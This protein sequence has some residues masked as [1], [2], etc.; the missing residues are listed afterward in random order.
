MTFS[1]LS[2]AEDPSFSNSSMSSSSSS[3]FIFMVILSFLKELFV[4]S[5]SKSRFRSFIVWV[6]TSFWAGSLAFFICFCKSSRVTIRFFFRI[7]VE[8]SVPRFSS[9]LFKPFM[10][11]FR[12]SL[13]CESSVPSI[14]F[15][16]C[17]RAASISCLWTSCDFSFFSFRA[18]GSTSCTA[19]M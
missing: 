9:F 8:S 5:F 17:S 6:R 12:T 15:C 3:P 14:R 1:S 16:S 2:N 7:S 10:A 18:S 11:W 4:S 19:I 13:V